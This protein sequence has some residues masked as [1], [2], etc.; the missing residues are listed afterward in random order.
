[1]TMIKRDLEIVSQDIINSYDNKDI[2]YKKSLF[3]EYIGLLKD[4]NREINL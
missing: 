2:E 1:M 4:G 3:W